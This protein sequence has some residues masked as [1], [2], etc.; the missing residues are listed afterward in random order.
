M[1]NWCHLSEAL[2]KLVQADLNLCLLLLCLRLESVRLWRRAPCSAAS[3]DVLCTHARKTVSCQMCTDLHSGAGANKGLL[4]MGMLMS[5]ITDQSFSSLAA[6][7]SAK[8]CL[9][10]WLWPYMCNLTQ[11]RSHHISSS[12]TRL[13]T[14][15]THRW[16]HSSRPSFRFSP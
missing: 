5:I 7:A 13:H 10:L 1:V 16:G 9:Y 11:I 4:V 12:H 2:G 15:P 14:S 8:M 3:T 6:T